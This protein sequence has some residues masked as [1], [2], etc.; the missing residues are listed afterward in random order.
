MGVEHAEV[1]AAGFE[2]G[3]LLVDD[4]GAIIGGEGDVDL[5]GL[6]YNVVLA[7][8]LVTE[9]VAANNDG[10]GPAGHEAGN[11]GDDDGLTENGSVEDVTDSAVGAAPHRLKAE[12]L[13]TALIGSNSG[14]LDTDLG[15]EH[16]VGTVNGDLVAGG[17]TVLDGKIIVFGLEV[18]VRVDMAF[19]NPLPDDA[20]HLVTVDVDDGLVDLDLSERGHCADTG[21][22]VN[23][24]NRFSKHLFLYFNIDNNYLSK[25]NNMV[26]AGN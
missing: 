16:S 2:V 10:L 26:E 25:L 14:T 8:V 5:A 20:G 21:D 22:T 6:G 23:A 4:F 12:L 24:S 13:N 9:G 1:A 19:L 11:V 7:P 17:I 3:D 18:E 15:A